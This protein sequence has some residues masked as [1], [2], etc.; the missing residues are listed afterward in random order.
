MYNTNENLKLFETLLKML[1]DIEHHKDNKAKLILF[2]TMGEPSVT[3][4]LNCRTL[5]KMMGLAK[6][7]M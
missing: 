1:D 6:E 3:Y 5:K 4:K 2:D 7:Q